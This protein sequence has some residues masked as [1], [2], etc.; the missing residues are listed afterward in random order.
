MLSDVRK[1]HERVAAG[2]TRLEAELPF[3]V[4]LLA[5][6]LER[7]IAR[8]L[9]P[10]GLTLGPYR[11]LHTVAA[12]GRMTQV[13]LTR[14]VVID[15]AQVSRATAQLEAAG[16]L[17]TQSDEFD[18]RRKWLRLST[19]GRQ[20]LAD[21]RGELEERLDGLHE[22]LGETPAD[23]ILRALDRLNAHVAGELGWR[24]T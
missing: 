19:S 22:A 17:E 2:L 7:H 3:Q 24:S 21:L 4:A 20:K 10:H 6:L 11:I 12:F 1:D 18:A 16:L 13:E 23:E 15:K 8:L 14:Y 5:R 9:A